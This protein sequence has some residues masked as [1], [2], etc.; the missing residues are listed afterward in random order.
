MIRPWF[1]HYFLSFPFPLPVRVPPPDGDAFNCLNLSSHTVSIR[2]SAHCLD[3]YFTAPSVWDSACPAPRIQQSRNPGTHSRSHAQPNPYPHIF[4]YANFSSYL[5]WNYASRCRRAYAANKIRN[6]L[7]DA[8]VMRQPSV[9]H[10]L[11]CGK[12]TSR[13]VLAFPPDFP[14]AFPPNLTRFTFSA[15]CSPVRLFGCGSVYI[16]YLICAR[17][18]GSAAAPTMGLHWVMP[19]IWSV[20]SRLYRRSRSRS[21]NNGLISP[22]FTAIPPQTFPLNSG[23]CQ[24]SAWMWQLLGFELILV[25]VV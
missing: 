14:P 24:F 9:C 4:A 12:P 25:F 20:S 15:P 8:W 13:P 11:C 7:R 5:L 16:A 1:F 18:P 10:N 3:D 22:D 19:L 6:K 2:R 17:L 23:A 21:H